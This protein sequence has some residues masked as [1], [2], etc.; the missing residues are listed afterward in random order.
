MRGD[1]V[2]PRLLGIEKLRSED[3]VR[4]AFEKQNEE[5]LTR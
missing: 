5:A 3:S 4:Q 2:L 1:D